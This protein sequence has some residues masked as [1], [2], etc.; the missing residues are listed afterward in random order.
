MATVILSPF[1]SVQCQ[2]MLEIEGSVNLEQLK[3]VD[4]KLIV[5]QDYSSQHYEVL[6]AKPAVDKSMTAESPIIYFK[7]KK[8]YRSFE[9]E[10]LFGFGRECGGYQADRIVEV[11]SSQSAAINCIGF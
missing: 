2:S 9:F 7:P 11:S 6:V 4:C 5:C 10:S 3:F 1:D 8:P